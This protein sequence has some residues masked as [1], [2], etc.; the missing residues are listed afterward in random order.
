VAVAPRLLSQTVQHNAS[1]LQ[2]HGNEG[3]VPVGLPFNLDACLQ[4]GAGRLQLK[5]MQFAYDLSE[6]I[7]QIP[8]LEHGTDGFRYIK[9]EAPYKA[10][11]G[12]RLSE[13]LPRRL[14]ARRHV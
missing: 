6:V 2:E 1:G 3:T 10:G 4:Q 12:V 9:V 5:Q 13:S 11:T 14:S 7:N 8:K